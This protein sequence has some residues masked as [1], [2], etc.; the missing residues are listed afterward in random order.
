[1]VPCLVGVNSA[2]CPEALPETAGIEKHRKTQIMGSDAL[3]MGKE[4][5]G[6]LAQCQEKK[7]MFISSYIDIQFQ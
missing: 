6:H 5:T 3:C 1:M 7:D 2:C 4:H